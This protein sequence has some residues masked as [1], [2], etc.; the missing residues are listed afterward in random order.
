MRRPRIYLDTSVINFLFVTDAPA[1][2]A[3]TVD[4]FAH[5]ARLYGL[6]V[7]EIVLLEIEQDPHE[8]HRGQLLRALTD[9]EVEVLPADQRETVDRLAARYIE[10]GAVPQMKWADAQH[11]AY[12]TIYEMDIL[13]SWNFKHLANV[14]RE[15]RIR[16]V[17]TEEGYHYPL[18]LLSPLEV[19]YESS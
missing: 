4:F 5:N 14:N 3:I 1:F 8:G 9:N 2:Q 18:R 6:Y 10:R 15:A 16:V 19:A 12:A 11:L 17:N 7:S 13:L